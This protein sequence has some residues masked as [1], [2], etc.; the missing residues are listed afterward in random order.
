MRGG[1]YSSDLVLQNIEAKAY[2]VLDTFFTNTVSTGNMTGGGK[3]SIAKA[4][5]MY[6]TAFAMQMK[7]GNTTGA[8]TCD[9][10]AT[11]PAL[12]HPSHA[13]VP[14]QGKPEGV[15]SMVDVTL[16]ELTVQEYTRYH[17]PHSKA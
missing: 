5:R 12:P 3:R 15:S 7:G 14:P 10:V 11:A 6:Q 1:S 8:P 9:T 13:F 2:Q 17:Y 4:S 16:P